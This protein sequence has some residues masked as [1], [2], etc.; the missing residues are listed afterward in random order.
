MTEGFPQV[1]YQ[2]TASQEEFLR[3][4]KELHGVML[5]PCAERMKELGMLLDEPW[6]RRAQ[7]RVMDS[8]WQANRRYVEMV[9]PVY[10]VTPVRFRVER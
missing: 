8:V 9:M 3:L 1:E 4:A 7:C 2:F 6:V 10:N 5:A